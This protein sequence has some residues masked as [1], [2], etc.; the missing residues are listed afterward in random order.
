MKKLSQV[1]KRVIFT[2]KAPSPIGPYSQAVLS[3]NHLFISGQIALNATTGS[4]VTGDIKEETKQVMENIKYILEAA[5]F[6][7]ENVIKASIFLK[8]MENF[9][10]VNEVYSSYFSEL[11]PARECVQVS[12]LPKDVNVEISI[13]AASD[14]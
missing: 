9:G 7:F 2:S 5:E 8:N 3:H 1:S 14:I 6:T 10:D 11:P 12:K 4:L 13:I